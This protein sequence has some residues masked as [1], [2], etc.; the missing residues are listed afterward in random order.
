LELDGVRSLIAYQDGRFFPV[1]VWS[2]RRCLHVTL[3]SL[4]HSGVYCVN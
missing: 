1:V 2:D 4:I 3:A